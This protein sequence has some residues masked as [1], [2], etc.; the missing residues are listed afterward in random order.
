MGGVP[1]RADIP[2]QARSARC[3]RECT[4]YD[5]GKNADSIAIFKGKRQRYHTSN[6]TFRLINPAWPYFRRM[7]CRKAAGFGRGQGRFCVIS[8]MQRVFR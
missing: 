8:G 3:N 1:R 5:M 7:I 6:H 2:H 4:C